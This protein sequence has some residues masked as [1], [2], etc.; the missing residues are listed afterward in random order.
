MTINQAADFITNT[1]KQPFNHELKERV[2]DSIR[3][4]GA[5]Y[6]FQRSR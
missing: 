2:K 1:L 6:L 3:N 4:K 5:A